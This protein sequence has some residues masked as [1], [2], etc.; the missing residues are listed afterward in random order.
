MQAATGDYFACL[1]DDDVWLPGALESMV[2]ALERNPRYGAV[3]GRAQLTHMDLT[4]FGEP[5]PYLPQTSGFLLREMLEYFP[6]HGMIMTRMDVVRREGGLDTSLGW[7]D[8]DWVL[9]IAAR[10]EILRID[11]IV[12]LFRQRGTAE[13]EYYKR[14]SAWVV[15]IFRRHTPSVGGMAAIRSQRQLWRHRGWMAGTFLRFAHINWVNGERRRAARATA[16][17]FSA[18]FPHTCLLLVKSW[19]FRSARQPEAR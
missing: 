1:D 4:P 18:S 15:P 8:W 12:L 16:Y 7:A 10:H 2:D 6:Q 19:P 5:Y 14:D 3:H 17:A 13:E 11:T 9:R